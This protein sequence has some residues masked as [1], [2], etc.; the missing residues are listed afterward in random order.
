[1]I[2]SSQGRGVPSEFQV[3]G[4]HTRPIP[5]GIWNGI[6]NDMMGNHCPIALMKVSRATLRIANY[7]CFDCACI[8]LS[9]PTMVEK[10]VLETCDESMSFL[11]G[12]VTSVGTLRA[13]VEDV[14][15][16][17]PKRMP[18]ECCLDDPSSSDWFGFNVSTRTHFLYFDRKDISLTALLVSTT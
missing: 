2:L 1:M 13:I 12:D 6:W 14:K 11:L 18:G 7:S 16:N 4:Y 15:E 5:T 3:A 10:D 9:Y 8:V 17:G